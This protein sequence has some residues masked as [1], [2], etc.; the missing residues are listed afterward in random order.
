[1]QKLARMGWAPALLMLVACS[2]MSQ[3]AEKEAL[4][5]IPPVVEREEELVEEA[6]E[7]VTEEEEPPVV[8]GEEPNTWREQRARWG[9]EEWLPEEDAVAE[10]AAEEWTAGM[11]RPEVGVEEP[12]WEEEPP[13][14]ASQPPMKEPWEA[15][16]ES[17]YGI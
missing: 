11:V 2:V 4:P 10:E 8:W 6:E 3:T 5:E 9:E 1:M 16:D 7:A 17:R 12:E 15:E 14:S 13:E